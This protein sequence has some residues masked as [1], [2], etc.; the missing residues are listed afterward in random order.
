[1]EFK[2][3]TFCVL[4]HDDDKQFLPML[5]HSIAPY[6][7]SRL[8]L[9][10]T[11]QVHRSYNTDFLPQEPSAKITL[12]SKDETVEQYLYQYDGN[13]NFAHAKNSVLDRVLTPW[14]F[15]LDCDERIVSDITALFEAKGNIHSD[16]VYVNVI[17]PQPKDENGEVQIDVSKQ[18]RLF[19]C[20][21]EIRFDGEI[22]EQVTES[23]HQNGGVVNESHIVI[24]HVGYLDGKK[25]FQKTLRNIRGLCRAIGKGEEKAYNYEML[26]IELVKLKEAGVLDN[27]IEGITTWH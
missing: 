13:F 8:I 5:I 27:V 1:M 16:G 24:N 2:D 20:S 17:A 4:W 11:K 9:C 18:I 15:F 7:G 25:N 12:K 19:R 26:R 21:D 23:I 6:V 3:I 10:E 14:C 22:H